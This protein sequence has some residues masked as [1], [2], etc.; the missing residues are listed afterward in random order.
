MSSL[1]FLKAQNERKSFCVAVR[2]HRNAGELTYMQA[3]VL[4]AFA[5]LGFDFKRSYAALSRWAGVS[6]AT[7][8]RALAAGERLGLLTRHSKR[9]KLWD[10][11][12]IR[13]VRDIITVRLRRFSSSS[14]NEPESDSFVSLWSLV[15]PNIPIDGLLGEALRRLGRSIGQREPT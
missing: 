12:R 11:E 7:I 6:R 14:Q 5:V 9:R 1:P 4:M 8:G 13:I 2:A 3:G 10:G 15:A